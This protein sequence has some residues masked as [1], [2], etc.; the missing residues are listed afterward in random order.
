MA[1]HLGV[2]RGFFEGGNKKLGGFHGGTLEKL[3]ATPLDVPQLLCIM[4]EV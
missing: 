1:D 2:S 4:D 3:R